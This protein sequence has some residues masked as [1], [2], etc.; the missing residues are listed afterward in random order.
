MENQLEPVRSHMGPVIPCPE[1][2]FEV[3]AKGAH[4]GGEKRVCGHMNSS[5]CTVISIG[6]PN[7]WDFELDVIKRFPHCRVHTFDCTVNGVVPD[8]IKSQVTFYPI[9]IG[10]QDAVTERGEKFLS[11]P[12]IVKLIDLKLP[13]TIMKM[14]IEGFEWT[15]I[16]AI[17]KVNILVPDSF[18]F[19]LHYGTR[20][21][22][23][24]WNGRLR[25]DPEIGMFMELLFN[26]GYVLVDRHDG[27]KI[28]CCTEL[29]IAK[30]LPST[31]FFYG[32]HSVIYADNKEALPQKLLPLEPYPTVPAK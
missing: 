21:S 14:D 23:V 32:Q 26:L 4:M 13:P 28:G 15:T 5:D 27:D 18:S 31:R 25:S 6:S 10:V 30:L 29:V 19:E 3:F 22:S 16:P 11:W 24:P 9:C 1:P 8:K 12:S 7:E 2:I 17:I 20:V